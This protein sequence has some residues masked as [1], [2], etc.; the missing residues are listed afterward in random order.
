M[1]LYQ[2]FGTS[3]SLEQDGIILDFGKGVKIKTRRAGGA[4]SKFQ[5]LLIK[6]TAPHKALLKQNLLDESQAL[7]I[8]AGVYAD[9]V[10]IGWEGVTDENDKPLAFNRENVIKVLLDLPDLFNAIQDA[11]ADHSNFQ[12]EMVEADTQELKKN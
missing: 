3:Q 4:N 10:I 2:T 8:M 1:G 5:K 12:S 11:T 6:R 7:E 9:A